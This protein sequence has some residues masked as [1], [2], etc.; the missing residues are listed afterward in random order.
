MTTPVI[1]ALK[2]TLKATTEATAKLKVT[3]KATATLEAAFSDMVAA[4]LV[5]ILLCSGI[6]FSIAHE[7]RLKAWVEDVF[8]TSSSWLDMSERWKCMASLP[9][10]DRGRERS[11]SST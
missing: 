4:L 5:T 6:R 9:S 7:V 11:V 2:V 1:K 10:D 3:A 8:I